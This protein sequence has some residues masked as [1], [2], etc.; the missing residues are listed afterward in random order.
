M[1]E[2]QSMLFIKHPR[3]I[4]KET[5]RMLG[6]QIIRAT[7]GSLELNVGLVIGRAVNQP[8]QLYDAYTEMEQML[9]FKFFSWMS[10]PFYLPMNP[11]SKR[12]LTRSN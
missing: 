6:D 4:P 7:A 9:E 3:P 11:L 1:S 8:A 10:I 12:A 2:H 5:L